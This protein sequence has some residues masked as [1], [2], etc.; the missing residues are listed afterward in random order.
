MSI[1]PE[2]EVPYAPLIESI[3]T[4]IKEAEV[5]LGDTF[6]ELDDGALYQQCVLFAFDEVRDD[7]VEEE[8]LG[9]FKAAFGVAAEAYRE[10]GIALIQRL[11]FA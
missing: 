5:G 3:R 10:A 7:E 11:R 6:Y 8:D 9:L 4:T 1:L 2:D